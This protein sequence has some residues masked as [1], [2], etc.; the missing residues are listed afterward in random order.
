[1]SVLEGAQRKLAAIATEVYPNTIASGRLFL[2]DDERDWQSVAADGE[3]FI[4]IRPPQLVDSGLMNTFAAYVDVC[5]TRYRD[6]RHNADLLVAYLLAANARSPK[7][8]IK[9]TVVTIEGDGY[10]VMNVRFVLKVKTP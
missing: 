1:M 5:H 10:W 9:P 2:P 8:S 7:T 3:V 6:A 4:R